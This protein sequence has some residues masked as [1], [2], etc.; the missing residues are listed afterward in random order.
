MRLARTLAAVGVAVA[1]SAC[2]QPAASRAHDDVRAVWTN[3]TVREHVDLSVFPDRPGTRA[4]SIHL[5][6]GARALGD[7][8]D[9]FPATCS[10]TVRT[11]GEDV[12]RL[13]VRWRRFHEPGFLACSGRGVAGDCLERAATSTSHRSVDVDAFTWE[14]RLD[15]AR[16]IVATHVH[17]A[18][19]PWWAIP[20]RPTPP[21]LK[22]FAGYWWGHGRGLRIAPDGR[23]RESI[24][25]GCCTRVIDLELRL[26]R[27]RGSARVARAA[28]TVTSVRIGDRH[29]YTAAHPPP[30]V[31]ETRT[32]RLR[33]GVITE[34]ITG[35]TYCAHDVGE[36][37]A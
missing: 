34:P 11:D 22:A 17:G 30:H 27:P 4:C 19:P 29:A 33:N 31:G 9:D 37:G 35:E 14:F 20:V 13:H 10:T 28:A 5:G 23:V 24:N 7:A 12:V 36:C 1:C 6:G 32:L 18:T 15:A 2:G 3:R 21:T 25:D 26:S 8:G 16:R